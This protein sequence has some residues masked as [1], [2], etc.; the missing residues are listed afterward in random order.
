MTEQASEE[1]EPFFD[2]EEAKGFIGKLLLVGVSYCDEQGNFVKQEQFHGEIVRASRDEGII[3]RLGE[4]GEERWV[5][6]DLSRLEPAPPG[7]YTLRASGEVVEDPDFLSM[8]TVYPP[9]ES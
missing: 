6:P 3:I 5:P 9:E 7:R 2:D 8:W 1:G 4:N